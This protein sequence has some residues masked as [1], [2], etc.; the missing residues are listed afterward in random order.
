MALVVQPFME[1]GLQAFKVG[2]SLP[3]RGPSC[4]GPEHRR[5]QT[6]RLGHA[7]GFWAFG[8]LLGLEQDSGL[9]VWGALCPASARYISCRGDCPRH[10][11]GGAKAE[12]IDASNPGSGRR[13]HCA[14]YFCYPGDL[15]WLGATPEAG[16]GRESLSTSAFDL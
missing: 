11:G 1:F 14:H 7:Q 13:Y 8:L 12:G 9:K 15:C 6:L 16:Y 4:G 5:C 10:R 2:S 3:G